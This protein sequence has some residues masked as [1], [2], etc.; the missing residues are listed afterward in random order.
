MSTP[1]IDVP[2]RQN[3]NRLL[4]TLTRE[5]YERLAPNLKRVSLQ[6]GEIVYKAGDAV[7]FVYFVGSG[8]LS[9]FSTTE[10]GETIE[11]AMIGR[12]GVTGVPSALSINRMPYGVIVRAQGDAMQMHA[13]VLRDEFDRGGNLRRL[14]LD[15]THA[16]FTQV[17]QSA[18]CNRFHTLEQR[19][20]RWLL[21]TRDEVQR[22]TFDLTHEFISQ[23]LGTQ[24]TLVTA[25]AGALHEAGL[26]RCHYGRITI[27]DSRGLEDAA[28]ECYAVV[29]RELH[30]AAGPR[31]LH[32][33][34]PE[35]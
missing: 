21:L 27:L 11:V 32:A 2:S 34:D 33:S 25:A 35:V 7:R 29:S 3:A 5:E 20:A 26:I 24:R 6:R 15:Y 16:L 23:M 8:M 31:S 22:T 12:E 17:A 18:V 28:C 13:G 1:T 19:L 9:L 30:R 10:E 4:A 14:L